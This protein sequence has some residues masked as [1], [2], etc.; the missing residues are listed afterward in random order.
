MCRF[1]A[2]LDHVPVTSII[3][4]H[5][6]TLKLFY[7]PTTAGGDAETI[8]EQYDLQ[9]RRQVDIDPATN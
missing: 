7:G 3:S 1:A 2:F 9:T 8:S 6:V 4:I 5:T